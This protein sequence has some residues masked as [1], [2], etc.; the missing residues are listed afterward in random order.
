MRSWRA[1]APDSCTSRQSGAA[2]G[3]GQYVRGIWVPRSADRGPRSVELP[4]SSHGLGCSRC[5]CRSPP[6]SGGALS[7]LGSR[8]ATGPVQPGE[9]EGYYGVIARAVGHETAGPNRPQPPTGRPG[10]PPARHRTGPPVQPHPTTARRTHDPSFPGAHGPAPRRNGIA[11]GSDG[12]AGSRGRR[13]PLVPRSPANP[14][15]TTEGST[16]AEAKGVVCEPHPDA[17]VRQESSAAGR[18]LLR[19]G[20][21]AVIAPEGR[22]RGSG[23]LRRNSPRTPRWLLAPPQKRFN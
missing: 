14:P 23:L 19:V 17:A 18:R 9:P 20:Y 7:Y 2:A 4:A 11:P 12:A 22:A 6:S 13:R 1:R 3:T 10:R 5:L 21:Y 15:E 8:S 16:T